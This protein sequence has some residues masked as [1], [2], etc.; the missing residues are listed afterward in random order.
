MGPIF[1]NINIHVLYYHLLHLYASSKVLLHF[2]LQEWA[3]LDAARSRDKNYISL[4]ITI[5]GSIWI[6]LYVF[7]TSF[8]YIIHHCQV[9]HDGSHLLI[10][11]ISS[12]LGRRQVQPSVVISQQGKCSQERCPRKAAKVVSSAWIMRVGN[13]GFCGGKTWGLGMACSLV[14]TAAFYSSSTPLSKRARTT[15][16]LQRYHKWRSMDAFTWRAGEPSIAATKQINIHVIHNI[17][18]CYGALYMNILD[19]VYLPHIQACASKVEGSAEVLWHSCLKEPW[20][21][22]QGNVWSHAFD[23]SQHIWCHKFYHDWAD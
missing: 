17:M 19:L 18:D 3:H 12:P 6:I 8:S 10:V 13:G 20:G 7:N 4:V 5:S 15:S 22:E 9:I 2:I 23:V 11:T 1:H 14:A 21:M 16:G